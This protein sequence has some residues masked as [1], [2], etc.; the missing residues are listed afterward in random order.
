MANS[1][2]SIHA[3]MSYDAT[4]K[5][6]LFRKSNPIS[7]IKHYLFFSVLVCCI[8]KL[9]GLLLIMLFFHWPI[10]EV[11]ISIKALLAFYQIGSLRN[12]TKKYLQK[13]TF[14]IYI[15]GQKSISDNSKVVIKFF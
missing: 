9:S 7:S 11:T 1:A 10:T 5:I 14:M 15:Y 4:T 12:A 3:I 2:K 8:R 13:E 6:V